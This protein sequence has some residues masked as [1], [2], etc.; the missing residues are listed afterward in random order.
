MFQNL[1]IPPM[2]CCAA[3]FVF[4]SFIFADVLCLNA[5]LF[6]L[7]DILFVLILIQIITLCW[8]LFLYFSHFYLQ[9]LFVLFTNYC[10]YNGFY[11][12]SYT[13]WSYL[14]VKPDQI[15]QV[16][17]IAVVFNVWRVWAFDFSIRWETLQFKIFHLMRELAI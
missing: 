7:F 16:K 17:N 8:L 10:L 3:F 4:M 12:Q 11:R 6:S 1:C 2:C 5:I 13:C 14:A 15:H 9:C